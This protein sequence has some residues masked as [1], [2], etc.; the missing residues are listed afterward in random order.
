MS[1]ATLANC[2]GNAIALQVIYV[3]TGSKIPP[4]NPGKRYIRKTHPESCASQAAD[5]NRN[6]WDDSS[7]EDP[8]CTCTTL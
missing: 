4:T 6:Q 8:E 2:F 5:G 7:D 1:Q 3:D